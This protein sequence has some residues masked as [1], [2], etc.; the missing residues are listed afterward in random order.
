[1]ERQMFPVYDKASE[2]LNA[3]PGG[4]LLTA[5]ANGRTNT[6][7]IG[8]GTLGME[9]GIPIFTAFVR[10]GRFTRELLDANPEFTINVPVGDFERKILGF[11]GTKSGRD[12]DKFRELGLTAVPGVEVSV[13]AIAQLPLTLECRV[14]YRRAQNPDAIPP[15]FLEKYYP[16]DVGSDATGSNRDFHIAYM[17]EVVSAYLLQP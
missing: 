10:T 4:I 12:V 8:W 9:W 3:L 6:M 11:C 17:G 15:R 7:T 2:I 13:P 16:Q 5:A 14:I 1:M